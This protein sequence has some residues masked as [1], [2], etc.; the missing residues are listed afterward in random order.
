MQDAYTSAFYG[1][2]KDTQKQTGYE[3]PHYLEAYIVMLLATYVKNPNFEPNNSFAESYLQIDSV[4]DAKKLGDTCLFVSGVFP[5]YGERKGLSRKYYKDIGR[6]SYASMRGEIFV[7]LT[8][9]FDLLSNFIELSST[10][11]KSPQ[12][13]LFR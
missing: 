1:V 10:P 8:T 2:V 9:H 7:E 11:P 6:S 4:R 12:S 3:L 13:N 5:S